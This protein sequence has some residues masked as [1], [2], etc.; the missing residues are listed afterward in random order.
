MSCIPVPGRLE[1]IRERVLLC[2]QPNLHDLHRSDYQD[3]LGCARTQTSCDPAHVQ[4]SGKGKV[5][6][7]QDMVMMMGM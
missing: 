1:R 3:R 7:P 4:R 5:S 2:L 6:H